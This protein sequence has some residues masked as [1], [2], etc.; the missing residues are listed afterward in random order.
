MSEIHTFT[1][2]KLAEF[3][4]MI[5]WNFVKR[6]EVTKTVDGKIWVKLVHH[7]SGKYMFHALKHGWKTEG[8]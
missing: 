3:F 1:E 7:R 8:A 4:T 2:D 5:D 6:A